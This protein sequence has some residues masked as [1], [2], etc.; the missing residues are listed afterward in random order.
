[1]ITWAFNNF[2]NNSYR[3]KISQVAF[4]LFP[5]NLIKFV[6]SF[7]FP[8]MYRYIICPHK[9]II[10]HT[11][12]YTYTYKHTHTQTYTHKNRQTHT[13]KSPW[14]NLASKNDIIH[15]REKQMEYHMLHVNSSDKWKK[16]KYRVLLYFT[17]AFLQF[18][19]PAGVSNPAGPK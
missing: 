15:W 2:W 18:L 4:L 14:R 16:T 6:D 17:V 12:T 10:P 9:L 3:L 11:H 19:A 5:I 8:D 1:M 7:Y 13:H